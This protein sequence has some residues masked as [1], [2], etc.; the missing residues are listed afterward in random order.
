[1]LVF[2]N[3]GFL[4]SSRSILVPSVILS[5]Y[6]LALLLLQIAGSLSLL[7][8]V[9]KVEET[10]CGDNNSYEEHTD[11]NYRN[12]EPGIQLHLWNFR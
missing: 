5:L 11:N 6:F 3:L 1:M 7:L 10:D 4:L 2:D 8:L 12:R 9:L